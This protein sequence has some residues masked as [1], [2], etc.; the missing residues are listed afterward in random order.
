M[1]GINAAVVGILAAALY[2]P[3]WTAAIRD[4]PDVAIAAAGLLLLASS[5]APPLV[6]VMLCTGCSVLRIIGG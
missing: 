1:T 4:G 3:V 6:V 5:R 2:D